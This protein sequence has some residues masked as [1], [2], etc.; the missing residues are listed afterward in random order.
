MQSPTALSF[1]SMWNHMR[2]KAPCQISL[3]NSSLKNSMFI[4]H[5]T[6]IICHEVIEVIHVGVETLI[7][8]YN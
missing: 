8:N 7:S 6:L 1:L 3:K 4:F 2:K 5:K